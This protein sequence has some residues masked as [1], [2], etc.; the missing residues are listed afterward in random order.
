M[1]TLSILVI[2]TP[3][4]YVASLHLTRDDAGEALREWARQWN[5]DTVPE[6]HIPTEVIDS[7]FFALQEYLQEQG[8]EINL[9]KADV[10]KPVI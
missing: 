9:T 7:D 10:P 4:V 6:V 1:D 5:Q 8:G 3:D 2:D